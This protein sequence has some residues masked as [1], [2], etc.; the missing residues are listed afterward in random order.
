MIPA[1][2]TSSVQAHLFIRICLCERSP[3][4]PCSLRDEAIYPE[5]AGRRLLRRC[6]A[7]EVS[8][9]FGER[10][11]QRRIIL[12]GPRSAPDFFRYPVLRLIMLN[13]R[14]PDKYLHVLAMF[15]FGYFYKERILR[16]SILFQ[17]A[18]E[19]VHRRFLQ[20][21]NPPFKSAHYPRHRRDRQ[22]DGDAPRP[23][24]RRLF[25]PQV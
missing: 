18:Q 25:Y 3:Y 5:R 17:S 22:A 12:S 1:E 24:T 14:S 6:F 19:L 11:S 9:A 8:S 7:A 23:I 16:R 13:Q 21:G 4:I 15:A 10:S 20:A 2:N